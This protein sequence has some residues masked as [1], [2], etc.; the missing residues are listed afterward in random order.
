MS[1]NKFFNASHVEGYLYEHNLKSAVTKETSKNPN[2]PYI[3]GTIGIATDEAMNNV[4]QIHYT[5]VTPTTSKGNPNNTYNMLQAIIDG[6]VSTVMGDGKENAARVRVDSA[7]ALNEWYDSR[8]EGNPLIST[9][10]NEGGFIH[11]LTMAEQLADSESARATFDCDILLTGSRHVE[12]DDEKKTPEKVVLKGYIFD[13]RKSIMPVEFSVTNPNA[14]NYFE[15]LE[16]SGKHP[17]FTRIKGEQVSRTVEREIREESAFGDDNV[18]IVKNSQRDFVVNWAAKEPYEFD[19]E[20]TL[21]AS[22]VEKALADREVYLADMKKRNDEYL[23]SKGN[24][25]PA[26]SVTVKKD[27]YDF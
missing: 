10:R 9:K 12:A 16:L 18:R 25:I 1:K 7:I 4:V 21:L 8:T 15:G 23:A 24:A 2:T 3:T 13:F 22:E 20:E 5:Y 6:K 14:M 11:Q 17:V 27:T 19:T 26:A